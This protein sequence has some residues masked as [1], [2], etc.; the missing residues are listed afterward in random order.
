MQCYTQTHTW[1]RVSRRWQI[2]DRLGL[3]GGVNGEQSKEGRLPILLAKGGQ[4]WRVRLECLFGRGSLGAMS[5]RWSTCA[6]PLQRKLLF[7][8]SGVCEWDLHCWSC[9]KGK[10][11]SMDCE[12]RYTVLGGKSGA[13][14][15]LSLTQES[16]YVHPSSETAWQTFVYLQ[17]STS[18]IISY[19]NGHTYTFYVI[20]RSK[21]TYK[22]LN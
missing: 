19:T 8:P 14:W 13:Y 3:E 11:Y 9:G 4:L 16:S 10:K 15:S 5:W 7:R 6:E 18:C 21:R 1:F 2:I 22:Q 12:N 17:L 20:Y